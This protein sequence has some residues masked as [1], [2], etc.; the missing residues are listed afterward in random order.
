MGYGESYGLMSDDL[1]EIGVLAVVG[2]GEL[3]DGCAKILSADSS[4]NVYVRVH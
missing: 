2:S 4:Y 1:Y 3:Y